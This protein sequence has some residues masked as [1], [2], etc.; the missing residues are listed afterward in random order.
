MLAKEEITKILSHQKL[1]NAN[2]I[3][4]LEN[5]NFVDA[6]KIGNSVFAR[7]QS[8]HIWLY[9]SVDKKEDFPKL[10]QFLKQEDKYF[11]TLE[12]WMLPYLKEKGD[13]D[14]QLKTFQYYLPDYVSIPFPCAEFRTLQISD[15]EY[16]YKNS[17][18]KDFLS[19]NYIQERI[20]KG[21]SSGM[22]INDNL[23]AWA[24]TQDDG[25]IGFLYVLDEYRRNGFAY[26]IMLNMI[27]KVRAAG[28]I[29]LTYIEENNHKSI[30][31]M[32][33]IGFLEDKQMIW[34]KLK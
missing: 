34:L 7:A 10:L 25:A 1:K 29:P 22:I 27:H 2:F 16:I 31:L 32:K 9:F 24:I 30:H 12:E 33:K 19:V 21:I 11:A 8:D 13:F 28:K 5:N 20:E 26:Q 6:H 15:A 18:Y 23:A 14:W 4:F 3:Y 17:D